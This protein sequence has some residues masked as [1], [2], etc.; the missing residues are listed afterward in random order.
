M[1]S[2]TTVTAENSL[3]DRILDSLPSGDYAIGAL[4]RLVDVIESDFKRSSLKS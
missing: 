2:T 3:A 4:L 1:S